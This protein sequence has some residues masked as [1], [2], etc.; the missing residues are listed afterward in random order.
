MF[1]GGYQS[2]ANIYR[3]P[4][5]PLYTARCS[6]FRTRIQS[7]TALQTLTDGDG[8]NVGLHPYGSDVSQE[9][10][11]KLQAS[12]V[13][14]FKEDLGNIY[15]FIDGEIVRTEEGVNASTITGESAIEWLDEQYD[16][17]LLQPRRRRVCLDANLTPEQ[18]LRFANNSCRRRR[19]WYYT[20]PTGAFTSSL[21][22]I[23]CTTARLP[24]WTILPTRMR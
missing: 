8:Y 1:D 3:A 21:S 4:Q 6:I 23:L 2:R 9:T 17:L 24:I 11:L 18:A 5:Q 16:R 15:Q 14:M 12:G 22:T 13:G 10:A 19:E 7:F 20:Q